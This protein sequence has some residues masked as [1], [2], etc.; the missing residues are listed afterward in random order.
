VTDYKREAQE[1]AA[2][3]R[4]LSEA[5]EFYKMVLVSPPEERI[6]AGGDGIAWLKSA[7]ADAVNAAQRLGYHVRTSPPPVCRSGSGGKAVTP[8][9]NA[10]EIKP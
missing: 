4:S 10:Q 8:M 6:A 7:A 2:A 9:G 3:I 1:L 5:L